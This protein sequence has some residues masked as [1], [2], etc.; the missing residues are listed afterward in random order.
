[1]KIR[2]QYKHLT[3]PYLYDGETQS[4]ADAYG[5]QATPHVFVSIAIAGCV[6]KA[7]WMTTIAPHW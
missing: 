1:M 2:S 4:V 5:P 7:V 3:Y 6:M